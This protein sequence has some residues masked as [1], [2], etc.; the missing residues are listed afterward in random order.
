MY[1]SRQFDPTHFYLS[2]GYGLCIYNLKY[3]NRKIQSVAQSRK[4]NFRNIRTEHNIFSLWSLTN[5]NFKN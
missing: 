4:L 1:L 5:I 3:G 2:F